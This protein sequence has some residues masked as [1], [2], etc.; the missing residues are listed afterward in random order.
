M[1]KRILGWHPTLSNAGNDFVGSD[2]GGQSFPRRRES[3]VQAM[4]V[5]T[6]L[7]GGSHSRA[8]GNPVAVPV[9]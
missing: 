2:G 7:F 3:S 5:Q 1:Q 9:G 8:G 6:N 4:M